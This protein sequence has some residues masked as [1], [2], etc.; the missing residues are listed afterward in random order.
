MSDENASKRNRTYAGRF[1]AWLKEE[2]RRLAMRYEILP[3]THM[4]LHLAASIMY[5]RVLR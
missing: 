2:F 3:E 5:W 4:E 1:F